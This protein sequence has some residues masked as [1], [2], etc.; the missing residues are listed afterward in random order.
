MNKIKVTSGFL[1]TD[2]N[3]S[4]FLFI[5]FMFDPTSPYKYFL[6][7]GRWAPLIFEGGGSIYQLG[8]IWGMGEESK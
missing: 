1:Y 7:L 6:P 5:V 2:A 4:P 3:G 8:G